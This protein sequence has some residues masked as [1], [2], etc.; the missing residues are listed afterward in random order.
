MD[1]A[2]NFGDV[3]DTYE[4]HLLLSEGKWSYDST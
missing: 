2:Q 3:V 1:F 4:G